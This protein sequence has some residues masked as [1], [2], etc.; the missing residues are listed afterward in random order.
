MNNKK[1]ASLPKLNARVRLIIVAVLFAVIIA[2]T[3]LTEINNL[4]SA[5]DVN[6]VDALSGQR[7]G[8]CSGWESDYLLTP[9][10]DLTL[11]RYEDNATA[12]MA[13]GYNQVDAVGLDTVTM[14]HIMG[15]TSGLEV[16]GE[17]IA[18]IGYVFCLPKKNESLLKEIDDYILEFRQKDFYPNFVSRST[19]EFDS[20]FPPEY[21]E[22]NTGGTRTIKVG[23]IPENYPES[24]IDSTTGRIEGYGVEFFRHFALDKNVNIEWVPTSATSAY[25]ELDTGK[26]DVA[27][28]CMTDV[29][30]KEAD[31]S[32]IL[33]TQPYFS[34]HVYLVKV[35]DGE[36]MK[37]NGEINS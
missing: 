28:M 33:M 3:G 7:I 30:R 5:R 27:V 25:I 35:K 9:R 2:A 29:Y 19:F 14:R 11:L 13:L 36:T 18:D 37:L 16:L 6:S 32:G 1:T 20:E 26:I 8:S 24:Y 34:G 12:I 4:K 23:Y 21:I 15:I 31:L 22:D 10:K 17:P